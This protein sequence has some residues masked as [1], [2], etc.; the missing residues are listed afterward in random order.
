MTSDQ[1]QVEFDKIVSLF[2]EVEFVGTDAGM[3]ASLV[4]IV[5]NHLE[6]GDVVGLAREGEGR[7]LEELGSPKDSSGFHNYI[8]LLILK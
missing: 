1:R 5:F 4:E 6:E 2:V 8:Q 7:A 3:L